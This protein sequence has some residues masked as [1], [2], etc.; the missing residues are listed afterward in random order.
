M[1][2][3][4]VVAVHL[5]VVGFVLAGGFLAWRWRPLLRVHL[6][7]IVAAALV[8]VLH[9]DCPLTA[10]ETSLRHHAGQAVYRDGFLDHYL[11]RPVHA[12]G[13]TSTVALL[14]RLVPVVATLL[15]YGGLV[16]ARR[17]SE[18]AVGPAADE[19]VALAG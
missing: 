4:L 2:G 12:A 9:L 5:L 14:L 1:A 17:R 7:V 11:V 15:A 18:D 13:M 3:D 6:P 10:L 19:G 8:N 16:L